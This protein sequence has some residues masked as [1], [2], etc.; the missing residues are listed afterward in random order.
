MLV[1]RSTGAGAPPVG[2]SEVPSALQAEVAAQVRAPC[3]RAA[4]RTYGIGVACQ[5]AP[6]LIVAL[7]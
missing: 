2:D 4:W 5:H 7:Q 3:G 6:C 1:Y